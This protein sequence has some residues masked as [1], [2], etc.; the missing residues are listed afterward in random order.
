MLFIVTCSRSAPSKR[1]L[2]TFSSSLSVGAC[3][4]VFLAR[5]SSSEDE[6]STGVGFSFLGVFFFG[7]PFFNGVILTGTGS[8]FFEALTFSSAFFAFGFDLSLPSF[9]SL[10]F[11]FLDDSD[12]FGDDST[13]FFFFG[14]SSFSSSSSSSSPSSSSSSPLSTISD[15]FFDFPFSFLLFHYLFWFFFSSFFLLFWLLVEEQVSL[16]TLVT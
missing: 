13:F 11:V 7:E 6:S 1:S 10:S 8:F 9:F 12:F 14:G 15:V 4:L 3:F 5:G 2:T 16:K